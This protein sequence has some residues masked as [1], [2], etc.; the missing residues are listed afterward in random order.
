MKRARTRANARRQPTPRCGSFLSVQGIQRILRQAAREGAERAARALAEESSVRLV[1]LFGSAA[2]V[3]GPAKVR[4]AD[5]AVSIDPP[6]E[7]DAWRRLEAQALRAA[8]VPLDLVLLH[9][10][11]VVLAREVAA[12]GVCLFARTPEDELDF[13]VEANRRYLDFKP[14]LAEQWKLSGERAARRAHGHPA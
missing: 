11:S 5:L 14:L 1:F 9:R 6:P 2:A 4:D 8:R 10:A 13:V 3:D 7:P 12:T